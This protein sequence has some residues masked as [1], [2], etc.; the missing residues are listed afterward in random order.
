MYQYATLQE[1]ASRV[2]EGLKL[3]QTMG[4]VDEMRD[5]QDWFHVERPLDV[6]VHD[7]YG[8]KAEEEFFD[9]FSAP[10]NAPLCQTPAF[11]MEDAT[12]TSTLHDWEKLYGDPLKWHAC[13]EEGRQFATKYLRDAQYVFNR[14]QRH[15]H[16][17][18]KD[19]TYVPLNSCMP[20]KH[21][22]RK[23]LNKFSCQCKADFPKNNVITDR[24]VLICQGM[25]RR[26]R[27]RIR[28]RRNALGLWQ[29]QRSDPW[30]SGTTPS[31]AVHF[32]SNSHTMPN[33]RL[34]PTP[35]YS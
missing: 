8:D 35:C 20:K 1:I 26:F 13:A 10:S 19:G 21:K 28:G 3:T 5:F 17:K 4:L 31:L 11:L 25:A 14:V 12:T 30:Q 15:V 18:Q 33:Y 16:K 32:R 27:L 24:T 23:V 29:G 7:A 34:P 22:K 2:E 9:G 6:E